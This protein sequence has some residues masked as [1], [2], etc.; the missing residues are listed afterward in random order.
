NLT[1]P[2]ADARADANGDNYIGI[3]D[4][5]A[6]LGNWNAGTPP[7]ESANIPEPATL[8][9]CVL[10]TLTLTRPAPSRL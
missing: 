8:T 6:V 3:E 4:L 7:T 5:N 1:V 10:L 9:L 2:P